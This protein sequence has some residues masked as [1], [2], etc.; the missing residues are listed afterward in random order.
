MTITKTLED[1]TDVIGIDYRMNQLKDTVEELRI[2]KKG[3][4]I[5]LDTKQNFIMSPV[6]KTGDPAENAFYDNL[7]QNDSGHFSYKLNQDDKEMYFL[8]NELT[9]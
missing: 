9:G 6:A 7:Y 8:T 2:G 1:G 4:A 3:S 5:L